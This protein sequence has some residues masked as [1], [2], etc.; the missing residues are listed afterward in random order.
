MSTDKIA[1]KL[2]KNFTYRHIDLNFRGVS[3]N[4][5]PLIIDFQDNTITQKWCLLLHPLPQSN[6]D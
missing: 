2:L 3:Q 4:S 6:T 5:E 1:A